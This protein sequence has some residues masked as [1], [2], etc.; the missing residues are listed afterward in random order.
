MCISR[1]HNYIQ[2]HT[3]KSTQIIR[4]SL[5]CSFRIINN[6]KQN[7]NITSINHNNSYDLYLSHIYDILLYLTIV[8]PFSDQQP[9]SA[10]Y[11]SLPGPC[12]QRKSQEPTGG[13]KFI[14]CTSHVPTGESATHRKMSANKCYCCSISVQLHR[15]RE[16]VNE[17]SHS[18]RACVFLFK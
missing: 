2:I 4:I 13:V 7:L 14:S 3:N 18:K 10:D 11:C 16:A 17:R 1:W 8:I 5:S 15:V 6:S 9:D 12:P